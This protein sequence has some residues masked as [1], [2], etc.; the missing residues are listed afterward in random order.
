MKKYSHEQ[1]I[2]VPTYALRGDGP[3]ARQILSEFVG[4]L[5]PV[6]APDATHVTWLVVALEGA[7]LLDDWKGGR[8]ALQKTC[9]G[10]SVRW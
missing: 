6:G 4:R 3:R 9:A 2:N 5:P 10:R 7:V 8:D 1:L